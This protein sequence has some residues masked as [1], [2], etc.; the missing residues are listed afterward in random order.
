MPA[1]RPRSLRHLLGLLTLVLMLPMLALAVAV[2]VQ[3]VAAERLRLETATRAEARAVLLQADQLLAEA[4]ASLR[5]LASE[6]PPEPAISTLQA[7]SGRHLALLGPEG[8]VL[9]DTRPEGTRLTP[10]AVAAARGAAGRPVSPLVVDPASGGYAL[11]VTVPVRRG[12]LALA[13]PAAE[14]QALLRHP[15]L[16]PFDATRYPALADPEGRIVARWLEPERFVGRTLPPEARSV[17]L[18]AAEGVWHGRNLAGERVLVAHARSPLSGLAV[19]MGITEAALRA[20]LWRSA[21]VILPVA[22]GLLALAV[23][24]T[25]LVAGR[26]GGPVSQLGDA[27]RAL[28]E[29]RPVP[30]L[31]TPV[32]EVNEA[33]AAMADA[34]DRRRAAEVQRDL[35]VRE[36]H[37]RVKNLLATAQSLATLSAR[38][39]R[40]PR[41]FA[42]QFGARLRALARTHTMLLEEPG[43][44]L[45]LAA[46]VREVVAPYRMGL[47]R[48]T[49]DGPEVKL[50]A[51]AAVPLGMVL[52]E[53]ATNAAKYGALRVPEGRLA[54]AWTL[55][56][57][58]RL[59]LDWQ[60][61]GGPPV[62]APPDREGFGSQLLRRALTGLP[63]GG[64]EV[65]WRPEG[66]AVRMG[67]ARAEPP[68]TS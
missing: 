52:H 58:G 55:S 26:I 9:L 22:L 43:G 1:T 40:E 38:S 50:P 42:Q 41:D 18:S 59:A 30:R 66:L 48:I 7:R 61:S 57:E 14:L 31:A 2:G 56:A 17:V 63:G 11:L 27:A 65:E 46:L 3:H 25:R 13:V 47:G 21:L 15:A 4:L 39:A 24:A 44:E 34:A 28:A 36:L 19:G 8:T 45:R 68:A 6:E 20:P 37:H 51:E 62:M 60:E 16:G 53:L 5:S 29:G 49:M 64:L 33:A 32:A 67:F 10:E 12:L 35:L 54:I 23:L